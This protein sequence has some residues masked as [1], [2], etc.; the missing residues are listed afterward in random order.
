MATSW[1]VVFFSPQRCRYSLGEQAIVYIGLNQDEQV[2]AAVETLMT[3]FA[4]HSGL[5]EAVYIIGEEYYYLA[6]SMNKQGFEA[7]SEEY[8]RKAIRILEILIWAP[9]EQ[10]SDLIPD[11]T[12]A[13]GRCYERFEEYEIAIEYYKKILEEWPDF[14]HAATAGYLLGNCYKEMARAGRMSDAEAR[15]LIIQACQYVID[16]YPGRRAVGA[17]RNLLL[18]LEQTRKLNVMEDSNEG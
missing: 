3:E 1:E 7:A 9:L 2:D 8:Y 17:S 10:E 18:E 6:V 14:R 15:T 11:A 5:I 13:V 16:R 12:F 4:D